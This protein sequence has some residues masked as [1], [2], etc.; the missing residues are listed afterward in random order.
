M[1]IVTALMFF[2]AG[3]LAG[4]TLAYITDIIE[5]RKW[6]QEQMRIDEQHAKF[7]AKYGPDVTPQPNQTT[8]ES[9]ES[10]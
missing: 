2:L 8:N 1:T 7:W 6:E 3:I 10:K 9:R 5:M 4:Y